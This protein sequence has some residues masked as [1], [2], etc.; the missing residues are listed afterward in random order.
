DTN[1]GQIRGSGLQHLRSASTNS[2]SVS[3]EGLFTEAAQVHTSSGSVNLKLQPGSAVR[4]DVKTDKGSVNPH[5]LQL[6]GGV[7]QRNK[8]TGALGDPAAN[9]TLSI[10]TG[11]GSIDIN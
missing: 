3:L 7:T 5:G 4:F 2:G 11:S 10:E 8:L 9:A 1:S 6:T